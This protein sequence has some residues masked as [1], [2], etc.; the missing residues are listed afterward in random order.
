MSQKEKNLMD[1]ARNAARVATLEGAGSARVFATRARGVSVEWRDG[2]LDRIR[3][4]TSQGLSIDLFVAGRYSSNATSDLRDEQVEA[5]I[6]QTVAMTRYLAEDIHRQLPDPARYQG[7]TSADLQKS[8]PSIKEMTPEK[9]LQTA[10]RLEDA[11]RSVDREKQIVSVTSSVGDNEGLWVGFST[12]GFEASERGSSFSRWV[13][14]S[15]SGEEGRK[16]R[17]S[18]YGS[19]RFLADLPQESALG[20]EALKRAQDQLGSKQVNTGRYEV[21]I[22][23]RAVPTLTRHLLSPLSGGAIQQKRSFLEG[24]LG[25]QIGSD[26]LT[27]TSNP[28]LPRGLASSVWDGEGMATAP[29]AVFD[30]GVLKTFLLDTYYASKLGVAPT[31]GGLSNLIWTAGQRDADQIIGGMKEGLFVTSF[32]GGNSNPTTGDFSLGIKGFYVKD[33]AVVHPVS[34]MNMA[35][36]HLSFWKRLAEVGSDPWPYSSNRSPT[37]RF[38]DVQCSGA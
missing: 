38:T 37:L 35:G 9:R 4:S 18:G 32:L 29:R 6:K 25:D 22:E 11:A 1:L 24:R 26:L 30:R 34:E 10:K 21:V 13:S 36:N 7:A 23:N 5:Y 16:P 17:G 15:I 28:H 3:E 27:M 12:N 14:A 31:T 33:G 8:D 19:A 2:K 20:P